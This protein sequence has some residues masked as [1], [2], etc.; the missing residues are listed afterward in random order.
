MEILKVI[1]AAAAAFGFG[2]FWY[3]RM[4]Q[5]W[6]EAAGIKAGPDGRPEAGASPTPMVIGAVA[7]VL[8]AGMM[9]HVFATS[10]LD[11]ILEGIMGGAG[12]GAFF[13]TPWVAMNY[14]F[15]QRTFALWWIDSA[16]AVVGCTIMGI[17]LTVL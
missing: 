1:V 11:T 7:M 10:G 13:I 8:V 2:A 14:A 16:N 4:A 9:R 5:R 6:M 15:G 3:M 12:I 17:V